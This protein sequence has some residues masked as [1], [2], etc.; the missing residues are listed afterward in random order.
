MA[1][2]DVGR[3]NDITPCEG[4]KKYFLI[5]LGRLIQER[6]FQFVLCDLRPAMN[7]LFNIIEWICSPCQIIC[8]FIINPYNSIF[9]K[10]FPVS[11][12]ES[13]SA[14]RKR[15]LAAVLFY[16]TFRK[17]NLLPRLSSQRQQSPAKMNGPLFNPQ[18]PGGG[19]GG[20][21]MGDAQTM[22]A[23]K[24]VCLP[25]NPNFLTLN[26]LWFKDGRAEFLEA[27]D[28]IEFYRCVELI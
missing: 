5:R 3:G 22:A 7:I 16:S 8:N 10:I 27:R 21:E 12:P 24:A 11:K 6:R 15:R 26:R 17:P 28:G 2:W 19:G 14:S 13:S 9:K 20:A 23:V 4:Y 1:F 25:S 18:G